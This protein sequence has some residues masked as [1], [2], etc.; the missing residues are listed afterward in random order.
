MDALL[1]G[2]EALVSS[3]AIA[4]LTW[5]ALA[6]A[7]PTQEAEPSV[8]VRLAPEERGV[9]LGLFSADSSFDYTALID[10]IAALGATHLSICVVWWQADIRAAEIAPIP[11]W[12]PA[13]RQILDATQAARRRGL[14]VTLLPIIRLVRAE[15]GEWR[16]R[17]AP[18]DEDAWWASYRRYLLHVASLAEKGGAA[19]LSVGSELVSRERSRQRWIELID[20][21]RIEAPSLELMYSA[22]WDHFEPVR[23]WDAVDVVGVTAYF[24]LTKD[25]DASVAALTEAWAPVRAAVVQFSR[26]LGR[27]I[28]LTEVGYPSLDGGAV[29]PWDQTRRAPVDLEEQR[30][31]YEAFVRGWSGE[32]QLQGVYFWNWFGFGGPSDTDYTPRN[33]P[34]QAVIERWYRGR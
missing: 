30:R 23:F 3:A 20:R 21:I 4:G 34:A 19:R 5:L 15:P 28:V 13:D 14:H 22:N 18:A 8:P 33:K 24:E 6:L 10:E 32:P 25:S 7:A 11:S 9:S 2:E 29:W 31:A 27:R 1:A 16:G 26:R 17:L 12:S